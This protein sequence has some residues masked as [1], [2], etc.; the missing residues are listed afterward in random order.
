M[1]STSDMVRDEERGGLCE[2]S[3]GLQVSAARATTA[4]NVGRAHL[5]RQRWPLV[6]A[7]KRRGRVV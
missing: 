5:T 6:T 3:K 2:A 4:S 7:V 1:K